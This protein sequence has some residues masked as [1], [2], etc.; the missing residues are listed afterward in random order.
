MNEIERKF[1]VKKLPDVT[2]LKKCLI[3]QSYINDIN[4]NIEIRIRKYDNKK[5]YIDSKTKGNFIRNEFGSM[6]SSDMYN[7]LKPEKT[8]LKERYYLNNGEF[9]DVYKN[10]LEGLIILEKEGLLCS[11]LNYK[12]P[13]FV[14]KEV[15]YDRKYKNYEL[16]LTI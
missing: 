3:V 5:H 8:I 4:D 10:S 9:L 11:V 16:F 13:S 6:I 12:I 2:G 7:L 1:L 14:N 15:T